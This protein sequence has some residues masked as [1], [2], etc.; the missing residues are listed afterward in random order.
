V[1]Q[2]LGTTI[3]HDLKDT[4][5]PVFASGRLEFSHPSATEHHPSGYNRQPACSTSAM[6]PGAEDRQDLA[7]RE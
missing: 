7:L 4:T 3:L 5:A 6:T 2:V 1:T